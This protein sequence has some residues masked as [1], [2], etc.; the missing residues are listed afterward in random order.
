[1][2]V[3]RALHLTEVGGGSSTK[4]RMTGYRVASTVTRDVTDLS[5]C[6]LIKLSM[7]LASV[8]FDKLGATTIV[9]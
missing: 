6:Y 2:I 4:P 9:S 5:M 1:M 8:T 3:T 7:I